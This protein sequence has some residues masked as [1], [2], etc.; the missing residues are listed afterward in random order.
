MTYPHPLHVQVELYERTI[1]P[2]ERTA[3]RVPVLLSATENASGAAPSELQVFSEPGCLDSAC[4]N[5][6]WT[7]QHSALVLHSRVDTASKLLQE[8]AAAVRA[9]VRREY[10]TF[11]QSE[12]YSVHVEVSWLGANSHYDVESQVSCLFRC[13]LCYCTD[14]PTVK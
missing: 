7:V 5:E 6:G 4:R 8:D 13:E 2:K 3:S 12:E 14:L 10:S 9:H 1:W 11:L